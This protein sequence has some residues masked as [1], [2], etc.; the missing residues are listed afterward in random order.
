[1]FFS[2]F[3]PFAAI[4]FNMETKAIT[5]EERTTNT[6]VTQMADAHCHLD[7]VNDPSIIKNAIAAGVKT[8]VTNGVDT[9]SNA[10]SIALS[11][12]TNI[13]AALGIDPEHA[14]AT[15][16]EELEKS[17]KMIRANVGKVVAIGEIG[18]DYK[19]A[20]SFVALSWQRTVFKRFL[21]LA[22]ELN[23]PVSVH[24]RNALDDVLSIIDEVGNEKVH[25]HFF[26]GNAQQA[27]EIVRRGYLIS[28]P[29]VDS[30]KRMKAIK[31]IAIDNLMAESDAPIVGD[32]PLAVRRSIALIA[33][34]K[35]I[36]FESAAEATTENVKR[37]FGIKQKG[38]MMRS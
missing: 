29:P 2:V 24:S 22:V 17:I 27:R 33:A 18:L 8:I 5:K 38:H 1:M 11:D 14:A 34:T 3:N 23:L 35:G 9:K 12:G 26:E 37:F 15:T 10:K 25:L 19:K 16:E 6:Q 30:E 4:Y 21:L 31:E 20:E 7:L 32:S 28:V 36:S 13:F